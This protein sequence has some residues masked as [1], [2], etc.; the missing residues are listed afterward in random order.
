MSSGVSS[1]LVHEKS[2]HYCHSGSYHLLTS[3]FPCY[4]PFRIV[5]TFSDGDGN[6][7]EF[8]FS[9]NDEVKIH[10]T[11]IFPGRSVT[12]VYF[13]NDVQRS[14]W[15]PRNDDF[16][17]DTE[18]QWKPGR[19]WTAVFGM[20]LHIHIM[21]LGITVLVRTLL[22]LRFPTCSRCSA[23]IVAYFPVSFPG[24]FS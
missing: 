11:H 5:Y 10:K 1:L 4:P 13:E 23:R 19:T 16:F 2:V 18:K 8:K 7:K 12:R 6:T 15:F 17:W 21:L 14:R 20:F 22:C 24:S 9:R 3:R